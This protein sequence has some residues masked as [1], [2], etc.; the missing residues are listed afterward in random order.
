MIKKIVLLFILFQFSSLLSQDIETTLQEIADDYGVMGMSLYVNVNGAVSETYIGLRDFTRN[1]PVNQ[2]TKYRIAS[3]SKSF[4]SLGLI[5]LI[6]DGAIGL[7][8]DISEVLGY[9]LR[10]PNFLNIRITRTQFLIYQNYFWLVALFIRL[11]C[12]DKKVLEPILRTVI[13]IMAL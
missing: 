2:N 3:V 4:T 12:G 13:L 5:K 1:L 8:D 6:N 7:D 9:E 10:N 11:I